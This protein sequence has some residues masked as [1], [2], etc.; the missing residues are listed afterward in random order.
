MLPGFPKSGVYVPL[1]SSTAPGI[2]HYPVKYHTRLSQKGGSNYA[3][4][5]RAVPSMSIISYYSNY[6]YIFKIFLHIIQ[7]VRSF[8]LSLSL[9]T[10]LFWSCKE[11]NEDNFITIHLWAQ[12][13]SIEEVRCII[14]CMS[15]SKVKVT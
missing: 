3:N 5:Y 7:I 6:S 11:K 14:P 4:H 13:A 12:N 9:K 10:S 15:D 8:S 2:H 1:F